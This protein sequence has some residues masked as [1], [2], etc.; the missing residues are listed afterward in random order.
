MKGPA[1]SRVRWS[2]RLLELGHADRDGWRNATID[3]ESEHEAISVVLSLAPNVIVVGPRS[4]A[5]ATNEAART[6]AARHSSA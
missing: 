1:A 4:L 2:A 5:V 3:T 6:H